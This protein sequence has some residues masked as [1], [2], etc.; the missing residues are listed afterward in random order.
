[1][2]EQLYFFLQRTIQSDKMLY[3]VPENIYQEAVRLFVEKRK[4]GTL[5]EPC[6]IEKYTQD[7]EKEL[8]PEEKKDAR[9][10]AAF[11]FLMDFFMFWMI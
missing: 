11:E 9:I 4:A 10:I 3:A 6:R 1:M 2:N 8:T 5:P 7:E